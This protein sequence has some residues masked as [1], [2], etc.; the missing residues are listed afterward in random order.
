MVMFCTRSS[1]R[2]YTENLCKLG[3]TSEKTLQQ[4]KNCVHN[5]GTAGRL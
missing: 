5:I 1:V 2:A 3:D 4:L